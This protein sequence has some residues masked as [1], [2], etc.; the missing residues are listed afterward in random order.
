[1]LISS[2][3]DFS[4]SPSTPYLDGKP[5]TLLEL[6]FSPEDAFQQGGTVT[7]QEFLDRHGGFERLDSQASTGTLVYQ[8]SSWES[9]CFESYCSQITPNGDYL[10]ADTDH[11]TRFGATQLAKALAVDIRRILETGQKSD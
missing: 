10:F 5:A 8:H 4:H 3:P 6:L 1:M 9:L 11:L 2:L 7:R